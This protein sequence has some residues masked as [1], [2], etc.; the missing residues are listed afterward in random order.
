MAND[1]TQ[2]DSVQRSAGNAHQPVLVSFVAP[3]GTGKTT[4]L[5]AV[6]ADLSGDGYRI[7]AIKHDA[8]RIELDT[9]GKDSWRFREAGADGT[10]LVGSNQLAWFTN[11]GRSPDLQACIE[12]FFGGFDLVLVEGFRS[13]RLPT[14][15]VER[16]DHRDPT[17]KPPDPA[18]VLATVSPDEIERVGRLLRAKFLAK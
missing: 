7:G 17:W 11:N 5:E 12:L 1:P 13:A 9:E 2:D 4:L 18:L 3:S 10:L 16:P 14:I 8:H 6:I 15:L